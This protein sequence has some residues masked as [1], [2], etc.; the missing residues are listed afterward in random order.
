[1]GSTAEGQNDQI[2]LL[3]KRCLSLILIRLS[4]S[5][6]LDSE[7]FILDDYPVGIAQF[8]ALNRNGLFKYLFDILKSLKRLDLSDD[9]LAIFSA[10]TLFGPG[11]GIF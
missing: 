4:R 5:F 11:M 1:M 2:E 8:R 3:S 6:D 10:A 7:S 9:E